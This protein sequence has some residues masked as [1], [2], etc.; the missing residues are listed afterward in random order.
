M[1]MKQVSDTFE[2]RRVWNEDPPDPRCFDQ[3][4]FVI[5]THPKVNNEPQIIVDIYDPY[6]ARLWTSL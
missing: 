6:R 3:S 1:R 2:H 4:E 5:S